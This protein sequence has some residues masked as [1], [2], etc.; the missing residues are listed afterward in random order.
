MSLHIYEKHLGKYIF[1]NLEYKSL[2]VLHLN[3]LEGFTIRSI[4]FCSINKVLTEK[5]LR[6]ASKHQCY[7]YQ[8]HCNLVI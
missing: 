7:P 4:L 6:N 8:L 5:L 3:W 2:E 1:K